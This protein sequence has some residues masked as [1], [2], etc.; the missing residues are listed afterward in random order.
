MEYKLYEFLPLYNQVQTETFNNDVNSLEEFTSLKLPIEEEVPQHPGDLLLHQRLIANF[1]NPH[2]PYNGL[3][4]VHEMGTGKTCS[5]VAERFIRT[6]QSEQRQ[7]PETR[8]KNII[9]LTKGKE[10][11]EL[12][13]LVSSLNF[14]F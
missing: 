13:K 8:L 11:T 12:K 3:L 14:S 5:A 2:T 10:T 1:I 6:S 4:L 7:F 9:V